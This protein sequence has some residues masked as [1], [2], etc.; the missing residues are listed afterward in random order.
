[1]TVYTSFLLGAF[2]GFV[3]CLVLPFLL[4]FL[5]HY[6]DAATARFRF[7]RIVLLFLLLPIVTFACYAWNSSKVTTSLLLLL[8]VFIIGRSSGRI[9][10]VTAALGAALFFALFL[11]PANSLWIALASDQQSAVV[12]LLSTLIVGVLSSSRN[13]GSDRNALPS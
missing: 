2:I 8:T 11:P 6:F 13:N 9:A 5:V 3:F 7:L 10:G 1:M 4:V 12:F